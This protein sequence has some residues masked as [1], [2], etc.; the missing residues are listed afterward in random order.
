MALDTEELSVWDIAFRWVG[1]DPAQYRLRLPL[2]VRDNFR[3]LMNA[4]LSGEIICPTLCLDKLPSGSKA[5]PRYYVRTHIDD[6]YACIHG[7]KFNRK[8]L[9]WAT[10][11]RSNFL[12]WCSCRGIIP[13]EFWFPPGWK[14][15]Y[16]SPDGI[17]PGLVVRHKEPSDD[18]TIA[19]FSYD[20]PERES[21]IDGEAIDEAPE[22]ASISALRRNQAAKIACQQI[23]TAIWQ[24]DPARRIAEVIRDDLIQEYGGAKY[25]NDDTIREWIK[26]VA[27][28]EVRAR[29][30][31]PR[32]ENGDKG[33]KPYPDEV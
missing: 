20:W 26:V 32:K 9:K 22:E 27:P 19:S 24:K 3:V 5:D 28:K 4:I 12:E 6:V 10:L 30:G 14:H 13:P 21:E 7:T 29:R 17:R 23:A 2:L 25:F 33:D 18:N 31:R 1:H 11:E 8:L 16:E 15:E